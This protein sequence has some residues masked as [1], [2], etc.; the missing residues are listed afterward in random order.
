MIFSAEVERRPFTPEEDDTIIRAH[1]RFGNK[2][3]TIARL[4]NGRT[5][6]AIKNHWN[7]TLKRK[8]SSMADDFID[9]SSQLLKRSTT[10]GTGNNVPGLYLNPSSPSG[11]D[12]S[13]SSL[14]AASP[15]YKPLARTGSLVPCSQHEETTSSTT[16]PP[17][18]LSLSLPGSDSCEVSDIGPISPTGSNPVP[19]P[20][21]VA[22]PTPAPAPVPQLQL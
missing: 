2:W 9:D 11:S 7:S 13:D 16:D 6:N 15:I 18:L 19:S 12:M 5:D 17:T 3:A 10:L 21:L 20:T 22:A 8:C 4:L 14:P 1:I